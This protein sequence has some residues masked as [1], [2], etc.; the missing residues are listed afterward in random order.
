MARN[1]RITLS[2]PIRS[3]L[4]GLAAH[5]RT[6]GVTPAIAETAV[7][8]PSSFPADPADRLIFATAVEQGWRLIT[9]DRRIRDYRHPAAISVW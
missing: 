2:I 1:E 8:L 3:W 4:E 9:K 5:V 6:A 7:S